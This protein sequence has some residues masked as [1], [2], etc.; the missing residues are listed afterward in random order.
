MAAMNQAGFAPSVAMSPTG[1]GGSLLGAWP[2]WAIA[3]ATRK[4]DLRGGLP[5]KWWE[6]HKVSET[7]SHYVRTSNETTASRGRFK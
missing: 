7:L 3:R 5:S 6:I 2:W 4:P 1:D